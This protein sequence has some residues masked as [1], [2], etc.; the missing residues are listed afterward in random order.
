M[1]DNF[2]VLKLFVFDSE[3]FNYDGF[4]TY[5]S[6]DEADETI[7][8]TVDLDIG[9]NLIPIKLVDVAGKRNYY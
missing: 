5:L 2:P 7:T 6:F 1:K 8:V 9:E 4:D 3:E